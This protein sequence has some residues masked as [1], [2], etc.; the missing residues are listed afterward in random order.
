MVKN[1]VMHTI[2]G[3]SEFSVGLID[4]CIGMV[5]RMAVEPEVRHIIDYENYGSGIAFD[6]YRGGFTLEIFVSHE[7][8][9]GYTAYNDEQISCFVFEGIDDAVNFWNV[10]TNRRI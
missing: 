4:K 10:I 7:G 6:F 8:T 1:N 9:W 5:G 2:K 3:F